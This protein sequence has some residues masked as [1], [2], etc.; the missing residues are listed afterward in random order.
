MTTYKI[1]DRV[2]LCGTDII[3]VI[4]GT[5]SEG[6]YK[7]KFA[8]YGAEITVKGSEIEVADENRDDILIGCIAQGGAE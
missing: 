6:W 3:G 2:K 7:A 4:T 1:H 8:V 5:V